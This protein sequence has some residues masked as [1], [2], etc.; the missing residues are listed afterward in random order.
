MSN[1]GELLPEP[2]ADNEFINKM[3]ALTGLGG[4]TVKDAADS[5]LDHLN[6]EISPWHYKGLSGT[7]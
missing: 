5:N 2:K 1:L 6:K 7:D 4:H 3:L